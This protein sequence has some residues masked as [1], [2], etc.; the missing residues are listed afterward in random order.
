[1]AQL[2]AP[3]RV[4]LVLEMKSLGDGWCKRDPATV[5][6]HGAAQDADRVVRLAQ[7]HVIPARDGAGCDVEITSGYGMRPSLLGKRA[8]C[9]PKRSTRRGRAQE[10][11]HHGKSKPCPRGAG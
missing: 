1:M 4:I 11:A 6:P 10:R 3:V 9:A 8:K 7:R 2:I 5:L